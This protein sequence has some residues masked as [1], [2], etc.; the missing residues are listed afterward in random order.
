MNTIVPV[1][2]EYEKIEL[3][4]YKLRTESFVLHFENTE[5]NLAKAF[6]KLVEDIQKLI[7]G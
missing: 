5:D 6:V 1:E 2:T 7:M 4:R 3:E